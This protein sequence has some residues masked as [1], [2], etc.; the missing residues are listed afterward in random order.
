MARKIVITSG[1]GGVGKTTICAILGQVLAQK[2]YK[3]V[4]LDVDIGLNNLD[5]IAGIDEKVVY[6]VVDI[7]E[8]KCRPIQAL[9][10]DSNNPN[11]FIL[12]SAHPYNVGKVDSSALKEIVEYFSQGFDFI[13]IDCPAGIDLGF[14]RAVFCASEAIIVTTPH[15]PAIRDANK[16]ASILNGYNLNSVNLIVNRVRQDLVQSKQ[17][18]SANE[19]AKALSLSLVGV[20]SES[21]EISS[22]TSICGQVINLSEPSAL[23]FDVLTN[24]I[25][26]G[27]T[28]VNNIKQHSTFFERLK[29]SFKRGA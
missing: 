26:C 21:D 20:I 11:L 24:N 12:P 9:I 10:R 7:L 29:R 1:K 22:K 15:I 16:V 25:S 19:I 6:D 3:V 14:Q 27:T 23:E 2:G 5:V 28:G 18:L 4:L 8:G 13:L 17:M